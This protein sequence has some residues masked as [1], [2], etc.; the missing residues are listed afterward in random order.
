MNIASILLRFFGAQD[1]GNA[2]TLSL[3]TCRAQQNS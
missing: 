1:P 2:E 3:E